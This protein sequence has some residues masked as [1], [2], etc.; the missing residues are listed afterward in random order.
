MYIYGLLSII[1]IL[2]CPSHP[3]HGLDL[4]FLA[5]HSIGFPVLSGDGEGREGWKKHDCYCLI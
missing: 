2:F 5:F 3:S 4:G 1:C